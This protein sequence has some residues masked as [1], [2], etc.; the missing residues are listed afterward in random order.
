MRT[1]ADSRVINRSRKISG[2]NN[3]NVETTTKIN[4][5]PYNYRNNTEEI[6]NQQ[7]NITSNRSCTCV[8]FYLCKNGSIIT[9]GSGDALIDIR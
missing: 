2:A 1:H 6:L 7:L 4:L 8:P 3:K 5:Q 9:D